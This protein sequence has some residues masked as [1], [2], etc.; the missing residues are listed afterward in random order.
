MIIRH[1]RNLVVK[2]RFRSEHQ[3]PVG[4]SWLR[5]FQEHYGSHRRG[6][7]DEYYSIKLIAFVEKINPIKRVVKSSCLVM[8]STWKRGSTTQCLVALFV[9]M[10]S[11][12]K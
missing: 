10:L 3:P 5:R 12:L 2:L 11:A 7:F 4:P 8:S 1:A 9:S 6:R